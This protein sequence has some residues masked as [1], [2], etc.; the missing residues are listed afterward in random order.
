MGR[1]R[2]ISGEDVMTEDEFAAW[3]NQSEHLHGNVFIDVLRR[4]LAIKLQVKHY[5]RLALVCGDA[6]LSVQ[7]HWTDAELVVVMRSFL[8][9]PDDGAA[10]V[11]AA[12]RGDLAGVVNLLDRPLDPD[13]EA[14][15]PDDSEEESYNDHGVM[16]TPL[17]LAARM[18]HE[19]VVHCLLQA[20]AD[21]DKTDNDG[22]TAMH[23]AA[24]MGHEEV[25]RC[26]LQAGAD[27][28]KADNTGKTAM[29]L[30]V[31]NTSVEVVRCLL[32]AG[33]DKDKADN[34]GRTAWRLAVVGG[35]KQTLRLFRPPR[36]RG[37]SQPEKIV[38]P[39]KRRRSRTKPLV[40]SRAGGVLGSPGKRILCFGGN[41]SA[42]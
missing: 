39:D 16:V 12:L 8:T 28:D 1:V 38:S 37:K 6:R 20:G 13:I 25:V 4:H 31:M 23:M 5:R 14:V 9:E 21:K 36:A 2:K 15:R 18:G 33:A 32:Q 19:E 26:L 11:E 27:K 41:H 35:H 30:A 17:Q 24:R 10:L 3:W 40:T 22:Q 42:R 29:H 7:S 34:D